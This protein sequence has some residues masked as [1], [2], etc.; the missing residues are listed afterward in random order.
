MCPQYMYM[1]ICIPRMN[2]SPGL[3]HFSLN[4]CTLCGR[5]GTET[6]SFFHS[7]ASDV[8]I[9]TYICPFYSRYQICCTGHLRC[10]GCVAISLVSFSSAIFSLSLLPSSQGACTCKLVQILLSFFS[11][12]LADCF[13]CFPLLCC[14]M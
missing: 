6:R 1:Y 5:P 14:Y 3:P 12:K 11:L 9:Y 13:E 2:F 10:N 8:S 4:T 7:S